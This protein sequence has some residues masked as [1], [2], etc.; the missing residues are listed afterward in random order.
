M[1]VR[2]IQ[3]VKIFDRSNESTIAFKVEMEKEMGVEIESE[4]N[5]HEV[6]DCDILVTTTPVKSPVVKAGWIREGTHI[7]AIGADA[8]GKEELDPMIL[9]NA[10]VIVDA[11]QQASHSGEVNVPI[12]TGIFSVNEIYAELGQ[13]VSGIKQGRENNSDITVFDSTGLAIQDVV[14]AD[15]A[16]QRALE[17]KV[18]LELELF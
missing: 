1:E 6:C 9:K 14:T 17:S 7:N 12:S 2:D 11:I 13:V 10:K 15:L 8:A 4:P 18:G 3:K 16:Y 5:A